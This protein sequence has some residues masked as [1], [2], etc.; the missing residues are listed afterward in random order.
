[1]ANK[2][3]L[4]CRHCGRFSPTAFFSQIP[5]PGGILA[6]GVSY[7]SFTHFWKT[8]VIYSMVDKNER[9]EFDFIFI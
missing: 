2:L 9:S 6:W 3:S 4:S 8:C 5:T 1:V 7:R